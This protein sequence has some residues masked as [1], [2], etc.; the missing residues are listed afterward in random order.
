[1]ILPMSYI[2]GSG[3]SYNKFRLFHLLAMVYFIDVIINFRQLKARRWDLPMLVFLIWETITIFWASNFNISLRYL[4]CLGN[5]VVLLF[6]S[7]FYFNGSDEMLERFLKFIFRFNFGIMIVGVMEIFG[8]FRWPKN[9][10]TETF[11]N[12]DVTKLL[13]IYKTDLAGLAYLKSLPAAFFWNSNDLCFY[14]MAT[15]PLIFIVKNESRY[16]KYAYFLLTFF[17]LLVNTGRATILSLIIF[18]FTSIFLFKLDI[19]FRLFFSSLL[20][21]VLSIMLMAPRLSIMGTSRQNRLMSFAGAIVVYSNVKVDKTI[22][23]QL[24]ISSSTEKR[25][26]YL[27]MALAEFKKRPVFGIGSGNLLLQ[28]DNNLPTNVHNFWLE[29]MVETGL[30]GFSLFFYW[31]FSWLRKVWG[32]GERTK[33]LFLTFLV[34]APSALAVSSAVYQPGFWIPVLVLYLSQNRV[35]YPEN[36]Q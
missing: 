7:G 15:L 30:I 14:I 10:Y 26:S 1:M 31:L 24:Y 13:A 17:I 27:K 32:Q 34:I 12:S 4:F 18:L 16:F 25:A 29:I 20:I 28:Y 23:N 33:A 2:I 5:G 22:S 19:R 11:Y 8:I 9:F 36:F 6:L 21:A 35:V 3:I